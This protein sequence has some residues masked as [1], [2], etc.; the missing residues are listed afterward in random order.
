[1]TGMLV[2]VRNLDEAQLALAGGA[3]V[4]DI[5][6]PARGALGAVAVA[7]VSRIVAW[8]RGRPVQVSATAGDLPSDPMLVL[9]AVRAL[10]ATG[11]DFVKVGLLEPVHYRELLPA[12]QSCTHAGIN[13]ILV[14]FADRTPTVTPIMELAKQCGCVGVM[15]DTADKGSGSLRTLCSDAA[16]ADAVSLATRLDLMF[17]LAGSLR[18]DDIEPLL[19]LGADYLGFRGAVCDQTVRTEGLDV[20]R[21]AAV[22]RRIPRLAQVAS[23]PYPTVGVEYARGG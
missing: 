8:L 9:P 12:L 16:L 21:L 4:I 15:L 6:E 18:L 14:I 17:G 1:M 19:P 7:E 13:I 10:H 11:V 20:A 22:R 3:D 5:K 2:S 23:E